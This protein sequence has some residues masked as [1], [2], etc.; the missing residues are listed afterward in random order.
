MFKD[1]MR[2]TIKVYV[3]DKIIKSKNLED[4]AANNVEAFDVLNKVGM[5]LNLV[6]CTFGIKIKKF[7][8]Y[9]LLEKGI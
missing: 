3:D 5:K 4:H 2:K 8:R 7:L 9:I 1:L 6:K